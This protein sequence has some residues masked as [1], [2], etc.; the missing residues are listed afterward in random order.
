MRW[1]AAVIERLSD[2]FE[3]II[4]LC[5]VVVAA[6]ATLFGFYTGG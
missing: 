1:L 3:A 4:A 5:A 2:W 6:L